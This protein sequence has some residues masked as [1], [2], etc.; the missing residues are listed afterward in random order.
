ME[1]LRAWKARPNR[2]PLLLQGARQVGKTWLM[3]EFGRREFENT[4]YINFD[5][6]TALKPLFDADLAPKRII[7]DLELALRMKITP[8]NTL[9]IFDEVQECPRA[10]ASLKYFSEEAPEYPVI[11]AGSLLGLSLQSGT[12]FPVGK[13]ELLHIAP[14]SFAEFMDA[15]G[16]TAYQEILALKD[17]S[18]VQ[19]LLPA[20]KTRFIQA[21]RY[22]YYIGGMPRAV[23]SYCAH[24]DFDEVRVIQRAILSSYHADFSKHISSASIPKVGIIWDSIPVQLAKEKKKFL[25]SDMKAGARASQFEEALYWLESVGLVYRV[26]RVETGLL[27]LAAYRE[28]DNFKLY[29]VDVGLLSAMAGLTVENLSGADDAVFTHFRGALTEQFVLQELKLFDDRDFIF[30]WANDKGKAEVDFLM[31]FKG[32]VI[33]FEVKANRNLQAKSLKTFIEMFRPDAAV[34]TSLADL[35]R[36]AGLF[37]IP[38]YLIGAFP[39]FVEWR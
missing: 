5:R 26:N 31:Q 12:S 22:Y 18:R 33:P 2:M 11:G 20:L 13:V 34:R 6:D 30:Y 37:D 4:V 19:R 10:L 21:L 3:Q 7:Q 35:G 29:L 25:Y 24:H 15:L 16:E 17:F 39:E 23:A 1:K 28:K 27:P 8:E 36:N 14:L 32:K 38:L 9:I